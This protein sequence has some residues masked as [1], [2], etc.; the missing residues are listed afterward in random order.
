MA[1]A[2]LFISHYLLLP[3]LTNVLYNRIT[4]NSNNTMKNK[5]SKTKRKG[6]KYIIACKHRTNIK[7]AS[8][9]L[10]KQILNLYLEKN[11]IKIIESGFFDE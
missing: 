4:K 11:S 3:E 7:S 10:T 8:K 1:M 6:G 9:S 5:N 2:I